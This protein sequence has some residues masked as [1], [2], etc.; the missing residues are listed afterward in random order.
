[1]GSGIDGEVS[2]A[3]MLGSRVQVK[4]VEVAL[5]A[6]GGGG[7]ATASLQSSYGGHDRKHHHRI[8]I[9]ARWSRVLVGLGSRQ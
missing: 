5:S 9:H 3:I 1:M 2:V 6:V 7:G 4:K 8:A